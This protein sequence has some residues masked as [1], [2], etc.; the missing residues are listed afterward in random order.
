MERLNLKSVSVFIVLN[1]LLVCLVSTQVMADPVQEQI[2]CDLDLPAGP[3]LRL[4]GTDIEIDVLG[5]TLRGDFV[6][7]KVTPPPPIITINPGTPTRSGLVVPIRGDD[8]SVDK[9]FAEGARVFFGGRESCAGVQAADW[10]TQII[11]PPGGVLEIQGK[12]GEILIP[13]DWASRTGG[14]QA[15]DFYFNRAR[16]GIPMVRFYISSAYGTTRADVPICEFCVSYCI[17]VGV[18]VEPYPD[19]AIGPAGPAVGLEAA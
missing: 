13:P 5:Q 17:A 16:P 10:D 14:G 7:E 19:L 2:E 1:I 18:D 4:E 6:F 9:S 11:L 15:V 8:S 12:P 3:F